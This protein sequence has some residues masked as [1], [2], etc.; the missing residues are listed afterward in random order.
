[1]S[2]GTFSI[3]VFSEGRD[4]I[5][6]SQLARFNFAEEVKVLDAPEGYPKEIVELLSQEIQECGLSSLGPACL[7]SQF[8][9][10]FFFFMAP[11]IESSESFIFLSQFSH[12]NLNHV[13]AQAV[14]VSRDEEHHP[15]ILSASLF[16]LDESVSDEVLKNDY[17][18][19]RLKKIIEVR[20][21]LN[22]IRFSLEK[23]DL[24][25]LGDRSFYHIINFLI[26]DNNFNETE[27]IRTA[28]TRHQVS[29]KNSKRS[30]YQLEFLKLIRNY[31]K[32][33]KSFL[34]E[35]A[36][37]FLNSESRSASQFAAICL[38]EQEVSSDVIRQKV[39]EALQSSGEW[40]I[41]QLAV[42]ALNKIRQGVEDENA[43]IAR[44]SDSDSD[45]QKTALQVVKTFELSDEHLGAF[46]GLLNH[47]SWAVRNMA[48]QLVGMVLTPA[49]AALLIPRLAD[50]DS[51]VQ[52]SAVQALQRFTL[53]NAELP[54]LAVLLK[55][56]ISWKARQLAVSFI[57]TLKTS[58]ALHAIIPMLSDPDNDVQTMT[59][60]KL[61][62]WDEFTN[63]ELP[64]FVDLLRYRAWKTR[65]LAVQFIGK[66]KT[67]EAITALIPMLKDSDSDVRK[68]TIA[69][70]R[71]RNFNDVHVDLLIQVLNS[72][73]W[74]ARTLAAQYLG[75]TS[76]QKALD[77]LVDRL[78]IETDSD[79][80][81]EIKQA[82]KNIKSKR[83]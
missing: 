47:H 35:V 38:A 46:E 68:S 69:Q 10:Q 52:K 20:V 76:S 18:L 34:V 14:E 13:F 39:K 28:I 70:L 71:E 43:L 41:R 15:I 77:A 11:T 33:E 61:N 66:I 59:V 21:P 9:G 17:L 51:D 8:S 44:L 60:Q 53:T 19:G 63:A 65:N 75:T 54:A 6:A 83:S 31:F 37:E 62:T 56:N 27:K 12:K 7:D 3:N 55:N 5:T 26:Q 67:D 23:L 22:P 25:E 30:R 36:S 16:A 78:L 1:M 79:A 40:E 32:E 29:I 2:L 81:R 50:S 49:A 48:T 57:A 24:N 80:T 64:F 74:Q 82:I 73:D 42:L 4:V 45:V 72:K 58:E